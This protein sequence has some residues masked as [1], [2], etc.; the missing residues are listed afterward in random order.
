MLLLRYISIIVFASLTS[1]I[2]F[3]VRIVIIISHIVLE[4]VRHLSNDLRIK[5]GNSRISANML[6]YDHV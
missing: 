1:L 6:R 5:Y 2:T 4:I 3:I